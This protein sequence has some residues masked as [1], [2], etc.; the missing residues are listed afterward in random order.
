M[1]KLNLS[2]PQYRQDKDKKYRVF[3][4]LP[5]PSTGA[6]ASEEIE[7]TILV[8]FS[9]VIINILLVCVSYAWVKRIFFKNK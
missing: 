8:K 5:R 6:P 2:I 7:F 3:T 4:I 9:L 1:Y